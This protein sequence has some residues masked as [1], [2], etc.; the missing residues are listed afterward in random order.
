MD[1]QQAEVSRTIM[2]KFFEALIAARQRQADQY[3]RS[4]TAGI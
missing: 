4:L 2:R 1:I 3:L